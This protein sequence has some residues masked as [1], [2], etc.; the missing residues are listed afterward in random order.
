MSN[1]YPNSADARPP[2]KKLCGLSDQQFFLPSRPL[3]PAG[4]ALLDVIAGR[5]FGTI[6]VDPPWQFQNRTGKIAPE[7]KRDLTQL[8]TEQMLVERR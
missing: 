4:E 1:K 7:H 3:S 6:L 8:V 5:K 2:A